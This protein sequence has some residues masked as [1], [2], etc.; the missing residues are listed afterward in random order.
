[1]N[2]KNGLYKICNILDETYEK[3][4]DVPEFNNNEIEEKVT[5]IYDKIDDFVHDI[6]K[7]I[8]EKTYN[9]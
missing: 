6:K 4:E 8:R 9:Y 1:M 5:N 7:L 2:D 3:I